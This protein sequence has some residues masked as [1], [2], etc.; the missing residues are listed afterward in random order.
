MEKEKKTDYV[1]CRK[2]Q[3][4]KMKEKPLKKLTTI[5]IT[6]TNKNKHKMSRSTTFDRQ[7]KKKHTH[8]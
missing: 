7:R 6:K 4:R 5:I 3:I 8:R 1:A 2:L